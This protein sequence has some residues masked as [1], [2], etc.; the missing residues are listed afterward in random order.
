MQ[1]FD[2][3]NL[4]KL[5]NELTTGIKLQ[6]FQIFYEKYKLQIESNSTKDLSKLE[7]ELTTGIKLQ[8]FQIFYEK[9]K[10]QIESNSTKDLL[11]QFLPTWH[12]WLLHLLVA[13]GGL[14][15]LG[16]LQWKRLLPL[17]AASNH[18]NGWHLH[19]TTEAHCVSSGNWIWR[20]GRQRCL[21]IELQETCSRGALPSRTW[22]IHQIQT[23]QKECG[24][25]LLA[26]IARQCC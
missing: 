18:G 22:K 19:A 20:H 24:W 5:E 23:H 3:F 14:E 11:L 17:E 12:W 4:C 9:Y 16:Q 13:S 8:L 15:A 26:W 1:L 25:N 6:L 2:K 7:N 10:L 21:P